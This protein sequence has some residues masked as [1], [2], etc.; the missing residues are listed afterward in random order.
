M[1]R[2]VLEEAVIEEAEII[3]PIDP[4]LEFEEVKVEEEN[5]IDASAVIEEIP[6]LPPPIDEAPT[7]NEG[8]LADGDI[9]LPPIVG[10]L[11]IEKSGGIGVGG[12][13][14]L[15]IFISI[16]FYIGRKCSELTSGR[17]IKPSM[18]DSLATLL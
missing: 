5:F 8:F 11:D 18:S 3:E 14:A 13:F 7:T 16:L 15:I 4:M 9:S 12:F 17:Q 6:V 2:G 10:E 1:M